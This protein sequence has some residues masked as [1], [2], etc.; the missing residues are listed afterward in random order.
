M[1]VFSQTALCNDDDGIYAEHFQGVTVP[2]TEA[3]SGFVIETASL[4]AILENS[5]APLESMVVIEGIAF[6]ED[7]PEVF[8]T[9]APHIVFTTHNIARYLDWLRKWNV[10][11]HIRCIRK[12]SR[13]LDRDGVAF[14]L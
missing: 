2:N 12:I 5:T 1:S 6:V 8:Q 9:D 14:V 3:A 11:L 13:R 4:T 10:W 7:L